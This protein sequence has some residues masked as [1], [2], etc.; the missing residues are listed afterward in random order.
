MSSE[1][2]I[3]VS[4]LSKSFLVYDKP[5]DRLKQMLFRGRR[6]YYKEFWALKDV[7]F[8]VKKGQT[9]GVIGSNGS[10]KSTLLQII[11][12][13]LNKTFGEFKV[14]GRVA[15]LLELGAGF[16]PEFTGVENV[17]MA[18]S[19]Y[20]LS[21][22]DVDQK[23]S[24]IAAFADIGDYI[25]QPV[26]TFSSG[27]YVRLAFS[28]IAHVDADILVIDE[29]L[30]VGDASFNQK[31]MRFL[32]N[33]MDSGTVLF[34]SHDAAA[35]RSL[36]NHAIW[37]D[38]GK[39]KLTGSPK[40]VSEKYLE[41]IYESNQGESRKPI[42]KSDEHSSKKIV[43]DQRQDIINSSKLRNDIEVFEFNPDGESFGKGLAQIVGVDF[44]DIDG[45]KLKW[46]VGG[47]NVVLRITA[48]S[49]I[50][51]DSPIIGFLI[52]DR[53]GQDVFGDN[54]WI[55]YA[56]S[57]VKCEEGIGLEAEF[58]F[59]MPRLAV[60]G[61]SITAAIANGSQLDHIQHHWIHDAVSFRSISTSV[62]SG[63]VGIPM[64]NIVLRLKR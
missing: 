56:D 37:I 55:S 25:N 41:S 40:E 24:K 58:S 59:Q 51:L 63:I 20:G 9:I 12:G 54:T 33:F 42:K 57:P 19:L 11:C 6:Q 60:G 62:S 7:S 30:A 53:F 3:E 49:N 43:K 28:V 29:A 10:G 61:Y 18:S 34:V 1:F 48:T 39:V 21:K 4:N 32:R 45:N 23:F 64:E 5:S 35:I 38:K 13:T 15:A 27:M 36:C 2:V 14:N 17:Y 46:I 31:C 22:E 44:K 52:K 47:E 26:K 16:N 50:L 8:N